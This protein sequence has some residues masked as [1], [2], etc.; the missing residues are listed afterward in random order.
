MKQAFTFDDVLL[1]PQYSDIKRGDISFI[2]S[3]YDRYSSRPFISSPMD[4]VTEIDMMLAMGTMGGFGVHHR[5]CNLDKLWNVIIQRN[6]TPCIAISPSMDIEFLNEISEYNSDTLL[7]LD[8]A[9]GHTR[10][11]L[12]FVEQLKSLGFSKIV[13]GNIATKEAARDYYRLGV[14]AFR[15]GLGGGSA[16]ITRQVTGVGVPQLSAV[17]NIYSYFKEMGVDDVTII[18]DGG[19]RNTGDIVKS[20]RFGADYVMLGGMLAGHKECPIPLEFRGMAS[21]PAQESRGKENYVVEGESFVTPTHGLTSV[22][23]TLKKIEE[24]LRLAFYYLGASNIEELRECDFNFVTPA[25]VKENSAHYG[26]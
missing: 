4:T 16:C 8:V 9:H 21:K 13:S 3:L 14:K 20:L 1:V 11:N 24:E 7:F 19:H 15:V 12:L 6:F 10:K 22:T 18:S 25:T 2:G 17:N 5:Y 26:K 23:E